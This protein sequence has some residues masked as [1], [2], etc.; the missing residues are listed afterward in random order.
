VAAR[1]YAIV[2]EEF[3]PGL[4]A[5]AAPIRGP[6]GTVVAALNVSG[7]L[8]RFDGRLEDAASLLVRATD[9]LSAAIGGAVRA[10][11]SRT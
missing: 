3:E 6:A 5:A 7:P 11:A 10:G 1:G 2:R 8:F 9:E 4:V